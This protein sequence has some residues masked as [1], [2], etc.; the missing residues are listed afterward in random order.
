MSFDETRICSV[1]YSSKKIAANKLSISQ[2]KDLLKHTKKNGTPASQPCRASG[3]GAISVVVRKIKESLLSSAHGNPHD[4]FG[5]C[6]GHHHR[7]RSNARHFLFGGY[8]DVPA[9]DRDDDH[10][11]GQEAEG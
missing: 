1:T 8:D 9:H 3:S 7:K 5:G 4:P 2:L 11:K 6:L 10:A